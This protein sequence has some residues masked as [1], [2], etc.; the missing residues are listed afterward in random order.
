MKSITSVE[1]LK[2][3]ALYDD[4]KGLAEFY[5]CLNFGLRSS[6]RIIY[7]PE[8]GS[9]DIHNEIDD[10]W[11]EQIPAFELAKH[12]LLIEAINEGALFVYS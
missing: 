11:Q 10:S 7:Y 9:F 8:T 1:E 6:K 4:A 5:I 3:E 2:K 12:T